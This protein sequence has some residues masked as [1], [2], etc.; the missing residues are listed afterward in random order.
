M[1]KTQYYIDLLCRIVAAIIMLQTLYFK[2]TG[3]P[4]SIYIFT[5]IGMEPWGR[6]GVGIM[7]LTACILLFVPK[8]NWLGALLGIQLMAGA[9]F[10][11]LTKL[12]I[13]VMGDGGYLFFLCLTVLVTCSVSLFIQRDIAIEFVKSMNEKYKIIK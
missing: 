7:E 8:F 5:T 4:E 3:A 9:V 6:I 10:F 13:P 2:F 11:H 12:G 1:N